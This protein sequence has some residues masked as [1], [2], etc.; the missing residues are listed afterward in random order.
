M[1]KKNI[2]IGIAG[3]GQIGGRLYKE[4]L[5]KKKDVKI[6]TGININIIALSAKNINKRRNFNIN[7]NIFY[8]NPLKIA[9]NTN[10]H[11]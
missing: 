4:I 8:K 1:K 9:K 7:K 5:Y 11:I 6:K 2:N 10:I 3:L